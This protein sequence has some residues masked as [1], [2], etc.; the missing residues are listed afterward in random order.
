MTAR[1]L[2]IMSVRPPWAWSLLDATS[3]RRKRI[4][5]RR[6]FRCGADRVGLDVAV[7]V[8]GVGLMG[9]ASIIDL[10]RA[11]PS[12]LWPRIT[13]GCGLTRRE[14]HDLFGSAAEVTAIDMGYPVAFGGP[15]EMPSGWRPPRS[16]RFAYPAEEEMLRAVIPHPWAR[17]IEGIPK[18]A[19][20]DE[21]G[22]RA[23]ARK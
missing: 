17:V 8:T 4:E 22:I 21:F 23:N 12:R 2:I 14:F 20:G 13:R 15:V 7:Y 18:A 10:L 5:L 3:V 16:W 6:S 1:P 19:V 11:A 9:A